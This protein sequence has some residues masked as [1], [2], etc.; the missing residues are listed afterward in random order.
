MYGKMEGRDRRIGEKLFLAVQ[1]QKQKKRPQNKVEREKRFLR[2]CPSWHA[3]DLPVSL[4][5][6]QQTSI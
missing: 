5:H 4:L 3:H 1:S 2:S 6:T